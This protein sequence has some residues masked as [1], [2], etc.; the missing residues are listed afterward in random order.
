MK[1]VSAGKQRG[2]LFCQLSHKVAYF[3]TQGIRQNQNSGFLAGRVDLY[4]YF[5]CD[6][7]L[8]AAIIEKRI[9]DFKLFATDG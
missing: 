1:R 7:L 6:L 5:H 4:L 8:S 9:S 2:N 3:L